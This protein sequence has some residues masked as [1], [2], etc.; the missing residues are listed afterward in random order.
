MSMAHEILNDNATFHVKE[1]G[2]P[3]HKLGTALDHPATARE[4]IEAAK[5][6]YTLELQTIH[7]KDGSV[8]PNR[9]AVV[10]LDSNKALGLVRDRYKI[11][12]NVE[13][14]NFFDVLVGEGQAIYRTAGALN[15]GARVWIMAQLP[16]DIIIGNGDRVEKY[17][18]LTNSHDGTSS[19]LMFPTSCRVVCSN[20]LNMALSNRKN[21]IAIRHTGNV[22]GKI[23]EARKALGISINYYKQFESLAKQMKEFKMDE[24]LT[25]AY[26]D[27]VLSINDKDAKDVS[28][29]KENQHDQLVHLFHNG[30][31][32][33]GET[34]WDSVNSVTEYMDHYKQT[35]GM[36]QDPTKKLNDLWFGEGAR[37]K[38]LAWNTAVELINA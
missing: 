36:N 10:K 35:R 24:E 38:E 3:W 9:N 25:N 32:N 13:A 27:K 15:E 14:F 7:L 1:D 28:S 18:L 30:K 31:G 2:T 19:L 20:T 16:G 12:Q 29:R 8:I 26:F 6:D 17:L 5:L 4:A 23:D 21:G 22:M 11:I 37:T 33:V 34:L